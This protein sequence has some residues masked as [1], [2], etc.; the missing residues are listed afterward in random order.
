MMVNHLSRSYWVAAASV[1]IWWFI[2]LQTHGQLTGV[3]FLFHPVWPTA[4][5][6]AVM[7]QALLLV[8]GM[9][10]FTINLLWYIWKVK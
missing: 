2:D 3:L 6:S 9:G 7:N 10:A 5:V 4:G 1:M 8:A